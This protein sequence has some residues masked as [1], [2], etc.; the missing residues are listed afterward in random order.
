[1]VKTGFNSQF[2]M[3]DFVQRALQ[4]LIDPARLRYLIVPHVE[5][6]ECGALSRILDLAPQA[7]PV[8]SPVGAM[9][10]IGD[11]LDAPFY[12]MEVPQ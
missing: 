6:D 4:Q 2:G 8:C 1:M 3:F 5:G 7:E 10:T 12:K 9:V 11:V